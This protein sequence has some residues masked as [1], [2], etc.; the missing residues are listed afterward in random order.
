[1]SDT[2][3]TQTRGQLWKNRLG[4]PFR[5]V[6]SRVDQRPFLSFIILLMLLTAAIVAGNYL[7]KPVEETQE[8]IET[9]KEVT[10]YTFDENP[11][12]VVSAQVDKSGVTK[13]VAQ[14]AGIVSDILVKEGK[15]VAKGQTLLRLSTNYSGSNI[16]SIQRQIAA[17]N[18]QNTLDTFDKQTARHCRKS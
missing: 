9:P 6:G 5:F 10:L 18:Y 4:R 3:I 7:R 8:K 15:K 11:S 14:S 13:I 12:I 16:A 17:T 1:M 2:I